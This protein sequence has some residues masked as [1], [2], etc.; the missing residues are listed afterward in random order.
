[1][2]SIVPK[3]QRGEQLTSQENMALDGAEHDLSKGQMFLQDV[4]LSFRGVYEQAA[5][6]GNGTCKP[7]LKDVS[8][9]WQDFSKNSLKAPEG[10][11]IMMESRMLDESLKLMSQI[12][13]PKQKDGRLIIEDGYP[14]MVD[15]PQLFVPVE[16]FAKKKA[17]ETFANA[18]VKVY[19]E[20]G[21]NAPFISV[22]NPPYGQA[23]STA[24]D[25]KELI[26][27]SRSQFTNKMVNQGMNEKQ[28]KKIA[29]KMIGAT[30]DTSHI[31]MIRKQGFG[32]KELIEQAETIAPYVKH[33]H[34]NDNLGYTHTDLPPGM[35]D[36]PFKEIMGKMQKAGFKGKA[37]FE[38]GNFFQHYKTAPH[39][40]VL[41]AM[42]S[43]LYSMQAQPTWT[44]TYGMQGI[45]SGGY[46]PFLPQTHFSTYGAGFTGLP[47]EL[48]GQIGGQASRFS[49]TPNQ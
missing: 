29:G 5:K 1:M 7:I 19:K 17:S 23:I 30:W 39:A 14:V 20:L 16:D 44:G 26:V 33:V 13:K 6:Y 3:L 22:E 24:D 34:L 31:S 11:R 27:K 49:G 35:G 10:Q 8:K 9:E 45:Y 18:A 12:G 25:L 42:G 47:Q 32:S 38:G 2:Q 48:G 37:I 46:G 21:D 41:E 43:P 4:R 28:A 36:V 40:M 15:A